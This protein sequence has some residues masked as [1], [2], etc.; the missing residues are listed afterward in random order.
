VETRVVPSGDRRGEDY[1]Q[2]GAKGWKRMM[3]R[4]FSTKLD[5][6]VSW[7][8]MMVV[9]WQRGK[10]KGTNCGEVLLRRCTLLIGSEQR[11]CASWMETIDIRGDDDVESGEG[12]AEE[13]TKGTKRRSGTTLLLLQVLLLSWLITLR[14]KLD[15][16]TSCGMEQNDT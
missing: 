16:S 2:A 15:T 8:R 7:R 11:S 12:G 4:E 14:L 5:K 6:G 9:I 1:G 3:V 10:D 13:W